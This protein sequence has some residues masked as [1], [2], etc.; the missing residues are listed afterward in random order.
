MISDLQLREFR[1]SERTT[2]K[3]Q[4]LLAEWQSQ[5]FSSTPPERGKKRSRNKR[6]KCPWTVTGQRNSAYLHIKALDHQL[7]LTIGEGL[8]L[9][10]GESCENDDC[11]LVALNYLNSGRAPPTLILHLDEGSPA[12]SMTWYLLFG[13]DL[14]MLPQRDPYHREW[15]DIKNAVGDND[16]WHVILLM[17]VVFNLPFGPW[18][19]AAWF[20]KLKDMSDESSQSSSPSDPLFT[21]LYPLLC[22]DFGFTPEGTP[23]HRRLVFTKLFEGDAFRV[24]GVRVS[25]RRWFGWLQAAHHYL[26]IWHSRLFAIIAQGQALGIYKHFKDVPLWSSC[27]V[28][29][30]AVADVNGDDDDD[31]DAAPGPVD[32]DSDNQV[33]PDGVAAADNQVQPDR[34][35]ADKGADAAQ[36]AAVA[37]EAS[38]SHAQPVEDKGTTSKKS[39][40]EELQAMRS[41]CGNTMFVAGAVM[42]KDN[43]RSHVAMILEVTRPIYDRHA[44][45]AHVIRQPEKVQEFYQQAALND[46]METM[47]DCAKVFLNMETLDNIGFTTDFSKG[48]NVKKLG[49]TSEIVQAQTYTA[50]HMVS[51]FA[52]V[53]FHRITSMMYHTH[54]LGQTAALGSSVDAEYDAVVANLRFDYRIYLDILYKGKAQSPFLLKLIKGSIFVVRVVREIMLLL[55][56]PHS[57]LSNADNRAAV[58]KLLRMIY[59]GWGQTKIVE[60][61]F[62]HMRERESLDTLSGVKGVVSYYCSMTEMGAIESHLR[63]GVKPEDDTPKA[64]GKKTELF[65][66]KHHAPS[67]PNSD[68]IT[69]TATWPTYSPQSS[70]KIYSDR[71]L[72]H[73]LKCGEKVKY[74]DS[75]EG[76]VAVVERSLWSQASNCWRCDLFQPRSIIYQKATKKHYMVLGPLVSQGL[77]VWEVEGV[78]LGKGNHQAFLLGAGNVINK[79]PTVLTVLDFDSLSLVPSAPISP[80]NYHLALNK[81]DVHPMGVVILQYGK[82]VPVLLHAAE[83]CF[84]NLGITK[85]KVIADEFDI[86]VSTPTLPMTCSALIRHFWKLHMGSDITD[87]KLSEILALRC[88]DPGSAV[89]HIADESMLIEILDKDDVRAF[90]VYPC[91][92]YF[93]CCVALGVCLLV[94]HSL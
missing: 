62:K 56:L 17:T 32:D 49:V 12:F 55:T 70:K 60:D 4:E 78:R 18:D 24:K 66:C 71:I 84:Y 35:A 73:H 38:H 14:R 1:A 65:S 44:L 23:E 87:N 72:L 45:N 88:A 89:A 39:G 26:P 13:R 15:N 46:F 64:D 29:Q 28:Q 85:L 82:V 52:R 8:K 34:V 37:V 25:L 94:F 81:R 93:N 48:L 68:S 80:I 27:L 54:G 41:S 30:V 9:F 7:I 6:P 74:T 57:G 19:G 2:G 67:L 40:K 86:E 92:L 83:R 91:L 76:P 58:N 42:A 63:T 22:K 77:V 20:N 61:V 59:S 11:A 21:A 31:A 53:A 33:Q 47:E 10:I 90:Q 75:K 69:K 3:D 16:Q 36:A 5:F 50:C 51:L 79:S 43:I